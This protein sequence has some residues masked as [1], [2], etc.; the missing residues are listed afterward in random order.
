MTA[1]ASVER[2]VFMPHAPDAFGRGLAMAVA[3][4][5]LLVVAL[6]VGVSWHVSP[7]EGIE[8]ELWAS[9]PQMAAPRPAEPEP[10]PPPAPEPQVKPPPEPVKAA[11][12][13]EPEPDAQIAI[14]KAKRKKE[15][16]KEAA[17]EAAARE[18]EKLAE[19]KRKD[20]A[21]DK[22]RAE[23]DKKK[24]DEAQTAAL[25]AAREKQMQRLAGLAGATGA[26]TATGSALQSAGPSADYLG[27]IKGRIRPNVSFPDTLPGNPAVEIDIGLS[28]DGRIMSSRI[29]K[30]S[31]VPEWDEAVLRAIERTEVLPRDEN[32]KVPPAM[33]IVYRPRD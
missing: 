1:R 33:T 21:A 11:P 6:S 22:R 16:A 15:L 20:E 5:L 24:R 27:R 4:H 23:L 28:P 13:V 8:A 26:P 32:G 7:P 9:V 3:A 18:A 31:G 12:V 2:D 19:Q 17:K 25:A 29:V 10:P 14:E 30:R